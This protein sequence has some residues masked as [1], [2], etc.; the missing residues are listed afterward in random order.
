LKWAGIETSYHDYL[1][2]NWQTTTGASWEVSLHDGFYS[3]PVAQVAAEPVKPVAVTAATETIRL[4]R[5]L[6][7]LQLLLQSEKV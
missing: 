6:I 7:F 5:Q 4:L 2:A 1:K 3:V